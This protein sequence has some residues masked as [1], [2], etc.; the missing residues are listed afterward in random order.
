MSLTLTDPITMEDRDTEAATR[1]A[2][3]KRS[4]SLNVLVFQASSLLLLL[5]VTSK[6]DRTVRSNINTGFLGWQTYFFDRC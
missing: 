2:T 4:F 3:P 1:L 5:G 6:Y